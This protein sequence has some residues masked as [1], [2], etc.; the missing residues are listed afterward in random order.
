[1]NQERSYTRKIKEALLS[2]KIH[3]QLT[4]SEILEGYLNTIYYGNGAYG[5]EVAAQTY[6]ILRRRSWIFARLPSW[7]P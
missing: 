6:F 5:I 1:M 4:K 7:Q 2:V 3:N